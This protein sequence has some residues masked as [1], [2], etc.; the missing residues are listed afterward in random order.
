MAV[1]NR[2][3]AKLANASGAFSALSMTPWRLG[4]LV[5]RHGTSPPLCPDEMGVDFGFTSNKSW[6]WC[7]NT[8]R[9]RTRHV[10]SHMY[11]YTYTCTYTYAYAYIHVHVACTTNTRR[12]PQ[13]L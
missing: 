5:M 7:R 10:T 1:R 11:T 13:K 8:Q 2:N 6:L 12:T 3:L 4:T 9:T